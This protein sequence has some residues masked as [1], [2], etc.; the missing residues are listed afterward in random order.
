VTATI[1]IVF[2]FGAD[3]VSIGLVGKLNHPGGNGR[4]NGKSIRAIVSDYKALGLA[5]PDKLIAV[6]DEVIQ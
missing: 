3:P 4:H 5:I 2:T 6:A 1:P